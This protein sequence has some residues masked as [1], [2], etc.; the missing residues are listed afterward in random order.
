MNDFEIDLEY[1]LGQYKTKL[2]NSNGDSLI[3]IYKDKLTGEVQP[4]SEKQS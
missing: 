4:R 1:N 2:S 3:S